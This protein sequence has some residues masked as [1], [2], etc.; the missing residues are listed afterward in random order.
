MS[1]ELKLPV[2]RNPLVNTIHELTFEKQIGQGAFGQ[3]FKARIRGQSEIFAVKK[4][5]I[6]R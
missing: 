1:I 4:V 2:R 3:V 6:T 5:K